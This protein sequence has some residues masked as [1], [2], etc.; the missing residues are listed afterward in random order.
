MSLPPQQDNFVSGLRM[1]LLERLV[2]PEIDAWVDRFPKPVGSFGY[3][4]WGYNERAA[5][6]G[7][8]VT[9]WLYDHY[10]RVIATGL[11]NIAPTGR[12]LIVANHSGQLPLD[13]VLIATAMAT[14]E[15]GPR[16]PRAMIER[17]F[18]TVPWIGN[19]L[20]S[21]GSVI[22]DPHNCTRM[23]CN[24]EAVIVFPEGTRGSGKPYSK[25]YQLQRFGNGFL[26]LA[27]RHNT[28]IIPVAV[29]GCEET[30]PSLGNFSSLAK[31][32]GLPYIP[33]VAPVVLPARV[34]LH[35]GKPLHFPADEC[36]EAR[37]EEHVEQVKE[38]ISALIER[39]LQERQHVFT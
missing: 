18:P 17:F 13:G 29:I 27:I 28:P 39:G 30:L 16:A 9:K 25:R 6:I 37:L 38:A 23:L 31:L 19:I 36:S 14:N 35:F 24:E 8:A 1:R 10:F 11:E 26:N 32:M 7:L 5:R 21:L 2:T 12:V 22:G 34:R 4:P 33:I 20:Q 3:D 15:H